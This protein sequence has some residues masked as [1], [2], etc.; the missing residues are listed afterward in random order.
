[1]R[2]I[3]FVLLGEICMVVA[4]ALRTKPTKPMAQKGLKLRK[5]G[6]PL[7]NSIMTCFLLGKK[8]YFWTERITNSGIQKTIA[9]GPHQN[10][11]RKIEAQL[12]FLL[13][14]YLKSNNSAKLIKHKNKS[15]NVLEL[16]TKLSK[17]F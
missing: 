2:I 1:M 5:I 16:L 17:E 3:L 12:S 8:A 11:L 14:K 15:Q 10:S 9:V 6:I 7:I 13:K 4:I